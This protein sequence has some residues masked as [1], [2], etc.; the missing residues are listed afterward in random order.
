MDQ[1]KNELVQRTAAALQTFAEITPKPPAVA[2][3]LASSAVVSGLALSASI[4][5]ATIED[6]TDAAKQGAKEVRLVSHAFT[7]PLPHHRT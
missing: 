5:S 7:V 1:A 4:Q 2:A 6:L 3:G